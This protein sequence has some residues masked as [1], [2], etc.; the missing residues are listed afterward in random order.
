MRKRRSLQTTPPEFVRPSV[1]SI[2]SGGKLTIKFDKDI[3]WP[4]DIVQRVNAGKTQFVTMRKAPQGEFLP[5]PPNAY[6]E[7]PDDTPTSGQNI[8]IQFP[9][10]TLEDAKKIVPVEE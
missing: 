5:P 3:Q 4:L 1:K 7:K 8:D 10:I 9:V 6:P 2:S